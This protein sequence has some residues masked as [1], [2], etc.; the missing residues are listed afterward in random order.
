MIF[1][2]PRFLSN[3]K[4][5]LTF[6]HHLGGVF[7]VAIIWP[8][9]GISIYWIPHTPGC[10]PPCHQWFSSSSLDRHL[11][12]PLSFGG[13]ALKRWNSWFEVIVGESF[14]QNFCWD[15]KF[16]SDFK[17]FLLKSSHKVGDGLEDRP[18]F[19]FTKTAKENSPLEMTTKKIWSDSN[20][21][22]AT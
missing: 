17:T 13:G 12:L 19:R 2:Q 4:M 5:S 3:K 18:N 20:F 15:K 1:H 21:K 9:H 6:H 7:S 14:L 22:M 11:R 16:T 10:A 8:D